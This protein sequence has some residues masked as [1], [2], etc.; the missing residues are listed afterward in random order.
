MARLNDGRRVV[1][2]LILYIIGM[3]GLGILVATT[4][5]IPGTAPAPSATSLPGASG[6]SSH[7]PKAL[8]KST[9]VRVDIPSIGVH[10]PVQA[11]G[12]ASDGTVAVPPLSQPYLANWYR[13]GPSPGE[14][15]NAVILGHVDSREVGAAVFYRL[16]ALV[17]GARISVTRSDG[18]VAVFRVTAIALVSK[19]KF[20]ASYVYGPSS[21]P[22]LRL[23][24]CGGSFD[25]SARS[26]RGNTIVAAVMIS[27]HRVTYQDRAT[28]LKT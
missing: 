13:D 5:V 8:P 7:G 21:T 2:G 6:A 14:A 24:T 22:G 19:D 4:A 10:A 17:K 16:G 9:P 25:A 11:A 23:V 27:S 15:G 20:P 28:P 12:V 1:G 26:Y 3:A 18:M